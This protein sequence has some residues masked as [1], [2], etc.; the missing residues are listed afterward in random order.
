LESESMGSQ[1]DVLRAAIFWYATYIA[2][3]AGQPFSDFTWQRV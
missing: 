3:H 2:L 1:Y